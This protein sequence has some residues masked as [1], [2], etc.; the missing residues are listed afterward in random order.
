MTSPP[1]GM[2][3]EVDWRRKAKE[4][5]FEGRAFINGTLVEANSGRRMETIRPSDGSILT[6]VC[7][8]DEADVDAGVKAARDSFEIGHWSQAHPRF[9]KRVLHE[10]VDRIQANREEIG[11]L[12]SLEMGKPITD[13]VGEVDSSCRELAF[14]AEAV[15][16]VYGNTVPTD[17]NSLGMSVREPKGVIGAVTPWNFPLMMPIYKLAPALAAGNSVVLKPAEQ[18][19]LAAI[20][21]AELASEAGLPDGVLNIV[22]GTGEM[23]GQALGLHMEVDAI[24]FTGSTAVGKEFLAYSARSNMKAVW[25]ECGGKSPNVVLADAPDLDRAASFAAET[26]FH[27]AGQVCNA[28]SRLIVEKKI[29]GD[30]LELVTRQSLKWAPSDPLDPEAKMGPLVDGEALER[31]LGHV[32]TAQSDGASILSGGGRSMVETGGYFMEPTVLGSVDNSMKVAQ[33]EIFGPVLAAIE[34]DDP[35]QATQVANDSSYGLAAAIWTSDFTRAH[36]VARALK[37]G[38]VYINCYDRGDNSLPFGGFKESGI[39]VDRSLAAMDKYTNLK[40][41]WADIS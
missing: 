26:I 40:T 5:D 15:D 35:A 25:L 21:L 23:A 13:A 7:C 24:T 10:L 22:P 27:G 34:I 4:L 1:T 19:S 30:F 8:C 36:R 14:F 20:R 38:T 32:T 41:I 11:L 12:I 6:S 29:Y 28:G 2:N 18:S 3:T 9:R 17:L 33:E 16:K 37:A 31:A 39:G